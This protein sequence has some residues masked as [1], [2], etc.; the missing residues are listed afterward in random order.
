MQNT[1]REWVQANHRRFGWIGLTFMLVWLWVTFVL[2]CMNIY[3]MSQGAT[4]SDFVTGLYDEALPYPLKSLFGKFSPT[5]NI[6]LSWF[7]LC[8]AAP[9]VEE[10]FRAGLCEISSNKK[11]VLKHHFLLFAGSCLGF[12]LLHGGGYYSILIQGSLG[13]G[14]GLLWFKI[15]RNDDGTLINKRWPYLANVFVHSAYNFCV[16]GVQVL[17]TRSN[18]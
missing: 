3:M 12:G 17:V 5:E 18:M 6:L 15:W 7:G 11:G 1:L 10:G 16:L 14:L 4:G 8:V 13:L 9:L 2:M